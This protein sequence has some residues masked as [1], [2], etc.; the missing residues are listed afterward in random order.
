M[1]EPIIDNPD[2]L[3]RVE[4]I[5]AI[6]TILGAIAGFVVFVGRY[7]VMKSLGIA[8]LA[9]VLFSACTFAIVR[10]WPKEITPEVVKPSDS[11]DGPREGVMKPLPEPPVSASNNSYGK[12][13]G[14]VPEDPRLVLMDQ[15]D[16]EGNPVTTALLSPDGQQLATGDNEGWV[17]IKDLAGAFAGTWDPATPPGG[18]VWRLR[19]DPSGRYLAV[20][21]Q[22]GFRIIDCQDNGRVICEEH[23]TTHAGLDFAMA[24]E[25]LFAAGNCYGKVRVWTVS[26]ML[27]TEGLQP[28]KEI[29]SM[30]HPLPNDPDDGDRVRTRVDDLVMSPDG[31]RIYVAFAVENLSRRELIGA[32]VD[33]W[34][35]AGQKIHTIQLNEEHMVRRLAV[36]P[37]SNVL[38]TGGWTDGTVSFYDATTLDRLPYSG[39]KPHRNRILDVRFAEHGNAVYS[40][41]SDAVVRKYDARNCA[42]LGSARVDIGGSKIN[43]ATM[44]TD[45]ET[46]SWVQAGNTSTVAQFQLRDYPEPNSVAPA[47]N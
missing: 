23:S 1:S 24:D 28:P 13:K 14:R 22:N 3:T 38:I 15:F 32:G 12:G 21:Y 39:P 11:T 25:L 41:G 33:L 46:M 20:G 17:V 26:D 35:S 29:V 47:T 4:F 43:N 42:L 44:H 10:T 40:I 7:G 31:K 19:F 34:D 37:V 9:V 18:F 5:A 27:S 45:G 36:N 6:A 16:F 2:L 30:S 8:A